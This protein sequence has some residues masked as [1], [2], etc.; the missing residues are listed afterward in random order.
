MQSP[1]SQRRRELHLYMMFTFSFFS[2]AT[3]MFTDPFLL[4]PSRSSSFLLF[5]PLSFFQAISDRLHD[6]SL[7]VCCL[8][9]LQSR[10]IARAELTWRR[11]RQAKWLSFRAL[12]KRCADLTAHVKVCTR[13]SALRIQLAYTAVLVVY[14]GVQL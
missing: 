8:E 13:L 12:Q 6:A 5:P 1:A 3:H 10:P 9:A 14:V 11:V 4:L 2:A 7:C